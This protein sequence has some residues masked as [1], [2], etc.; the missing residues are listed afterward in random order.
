V[1]E[2][3]PITATTRDFSF[4]RSRAAANPTAAEIE[5]LAFR[6]RSNRTRSQQ[7]AE[8]ADATVLANLLDGLPPSGQNFVTVSLMSDIPDLFVNRRI[9]T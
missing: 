9:E 8:T 6:R 3:S 4:F 5:V 1:N 7:F 2:P